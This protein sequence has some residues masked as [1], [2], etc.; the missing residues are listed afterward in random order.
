MTTA[1]IVY[2]TAW[3]KG[4]TTDLVASAVLNGF[5][6]IDTAGQ[7][8]HYNEELVGEALEILQTKHGIKREDLWIQT[9]FT[10]LG[11]QDRTKPLPYNPTD[12]L[13][14]QI[15]SSVQSSLRNLRTPYLDAL[16]LHSPLPRLA[17][18]VAAWRALIALQDAGTVRTIGVSNTYDVR[19]LGQLERE[20][21]RA[22]QIVQNR[23]F[24]GNAWDKEVCR[25]CRERGIQYQSF[26]TLSGSPSLLKHPSVRTI[27]QAKHCTPA[28]VLFRLAQLHGVTPLSGTTKE[29]HMRED[30]AAE[31]IDLFGEVEGGQGDGAA[32]REIEQ[33]VWGKG[34]T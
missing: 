1:K 20:T 5:R 21:G 19:V 16:L 15:Q 9:K 8:K 31:D 10:S 32:V 3:K 17:D 30:I 26:W 33:L 2:G 4:R 34:A 28:Q 25:Y 18:T 24:E 6:A 7:P 27:A 12:P 29:E 11:G 13:P 23:W 14:T 22:V